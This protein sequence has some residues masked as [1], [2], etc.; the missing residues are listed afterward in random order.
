VRLVREINAAVPDG[1]SLEHVL[2]PRP[3]HVGDGEPKPA[4]DP[5]G[6]ETGEDGAGIDVLVLDTGFADPQPFDVI[7]EPGNAEI[8][9]EDGDGRRDPAAGHGTH[10]AGIIARIAPC[11]T[12][13]P[14]RL[15]VSPV[16]ACSDLDVAQALLD[17]RGAHIINCSFAAQCLDERAPTAIRDALAKLPEATIVVAAAGN[18]GV[19]DRSWPAAFERVIAVGAVG[20]PEGSSAWKQTDFS[21]H[22]DWVDCCAPG[23]DVVS[24][25]LTRPV[26]HFDGFACWSGTSMAAP[27]VT[28][29]IAALASRPGS[30]LAQARAKVLGG[31]RIGAVG[32]FVDPGAL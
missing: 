10:V 3:H 11:A 17:H 21:N 18:S 20:R 14:P 13:R 31:A 5:G 32:A 8:P 30:D 28:G 7:P 22:G 4:S 25:F 12:I 6:W 19:P 27:A 26:E 24:T 29:A 16:G 1:A 2:L 15:L 9:D 23:V